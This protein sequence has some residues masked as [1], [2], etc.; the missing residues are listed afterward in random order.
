[1]FGY[2]KICK[3]ELK[4]KDYETYKSV[5]CGLCKQLGKDYSFITRFL[6]NYDLTFFALLALSNEET[7]PQFYKGKCRFNPLKSCAYCKHTSDALSRASALLVLMSYFKLMDNIRDSGFFGKLGCTLIRPFFSS[8]KNKARKRYPEYYEACE[9]MFNSQLEAEKSGAG[10]DESAEPTAKLLE[11]VFSQLAYSDK[12]K[13]AYEQFGYHLGKWIY[14]IDAACDIDD[15]IKHKSFNP[16]YNKLKKPKAESTEFANEIL[17]HSVYLLTSAYRLI[18]KIRF[19]DILD[20]IVLIG[21]TS[22]QKELLKTGK[23]KADE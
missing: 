15:D 1:M 9:K 21:L 14:L 10:I 22:T 20:N 12:I 19:N 8:W 11:F 23:E 7:C 13:P 17:N 5:Y 16:I 4:V 18:D 3:P 6:L 2:V